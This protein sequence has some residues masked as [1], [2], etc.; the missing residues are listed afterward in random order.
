MEAKGKIK[1]QGVHVHVM[2]IYSGVSSTVV[3]ILIFG[4]T[5]NGQVHAPAAL[6]TE[7]N[8]HGV[9]WTLRLSR[10]YSRSGRFG[11]KNLLHL[12]GIEPRFFDCTARGLLAVLIALYRL[13]P[14]KGETNYSIWTQEHLSFKRISNSTTATLGVTTCTTNPILVL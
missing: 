12:T 13:L 5:W 3:P 1:G 9:R 14:A 2:T 6:P 11:E 10:P 8:F 7:K 4:T